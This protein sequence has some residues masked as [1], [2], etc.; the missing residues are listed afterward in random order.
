[1]DVSANTHSDS[2]FCVIGGGGC[3]IGGGGC[4]MGGGAT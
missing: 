1:M 3:V 2:D 4:V